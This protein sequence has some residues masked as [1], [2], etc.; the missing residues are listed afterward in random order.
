MRTN[1]LPLSVVPKSAW[2]FS[3]TLEAPFP[4]SS[5]PF[6]SPL[7]PG[8]QSSILLHYCLQK[9]H[10][11]LTN[12]LSLPHLKVLW[13]TVYPVRVLHLNGEVFVANNKNIPVVFTGYMTRTTARPCPW[14]NTVQAAQFTCNFVIFHMFRPTILCQEQ[15]QPSQPAQQARDTTKPSKYPRPLCDRRFAW[16]QDLKQHKHIHTGLWPQKY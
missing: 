5:T 8:S 7:L 3:Q 13:Y 16:E 6:Y 9:L 1:D 10:V 2:L 12:A 11:K 15:S 14:C 4:N